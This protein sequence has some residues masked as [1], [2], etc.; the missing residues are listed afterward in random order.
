MAAVAL[1]RSRRGRTFA[2]APD[3]IPAYRV[4][5]V[6][7][8]AHQLPSAVDA[9]IEARRAGEPL[10]VH[11]VNAGT[12]SLARHDDALAA[13]LER[14]DLNL[15]DGM[16]L[17]WIARRRLGLAH[18]VDRCYGP[19][20]LLAVLA[21]P[22]ARG[23]KHY[24]YGSSPDVVE[25]LAANLRER[26][27]G[28]DIVGVESPPFR[29]LTDD[30]SAALVERVRGSGADIVWVGLGTPKQDAFVDAYRDRLGAALVAVGAAFDFH[31]GMKRQ[32]PVWVQRIGM[33]WAF[34]LLSEPRRL[35]KRYLVGNT[36]FVWGVLR[37]RPRLVTRD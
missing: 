1:L 29:P 11:L 37:D 2:A 27:P 14:A 30:E 31:A 22:R 6:R 7:V 3:P 35:W 24:F 33:E 5:G 32:A 4:C 12:L 21:A 9:I 19:D 8:D 23:L 16:P 18:M 13:L 28:V 34:R 25:R 20:L 36:R 10:A 17:V 15:P 26:F